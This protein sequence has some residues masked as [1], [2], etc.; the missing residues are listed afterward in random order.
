MV[1]DNDTLVAVTADIVRPRED[2]ELEDEYLGIPKGGSFDLD[3]RTE[4][5][6]LMP[7]PLNQDFTT[8]PEGDGVYRGDNF[9]TYSNI[10]GGGLDF[11]TGST[12]MGINSSTVGLVIF[13]D[14]HGRIYP[15]R[16]ICSNDHC[17]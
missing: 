10:G 2:T 14:C 5:F 12:A 1:T 16:L 11:E 3:I 8:F 15:I 17:R 7:L 4:D 9:Y 13:H 6:P